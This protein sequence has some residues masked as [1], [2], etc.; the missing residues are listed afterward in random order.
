VDITELILEQHHEQRRAFAM[1][2]DLPPDDTTALGAVWGRL[3][4][5][6]EVHAD[7]EERFFYPRLLELGKGVGDADGPDDEVQDAISDHNEIRDGLRRARDAETGT[8]AW[9]DAVRAC[10]EANDEH[11]AEEEREDLP[12]FR[13][14]ADLQVRHDVA[15]AFLTYESQ[16]AQGVAPVDKD[17]DA[18][19]SSGGSAG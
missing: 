18:Y 10:R 16:H 13:R 8:D 6:L 11:M 14:H 2:D 9:W 1:L 17:P 19:V 3:E 12:D 4:V 15:V 5:L 7:A